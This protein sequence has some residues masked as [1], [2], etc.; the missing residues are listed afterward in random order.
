[1]KT[2]KDE[3]K[4]AKEIAEKFKQLDPDNKKYVE[5]YMKGLLDGKE[6]QNNG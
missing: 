6:K 5:G 1:M 2:S 4:Q 3:Q